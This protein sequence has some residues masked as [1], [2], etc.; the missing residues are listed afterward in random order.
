MKRIIICALMACAAVLS[1]AQTRNATYEAYIAKYKDIALEQERLHKIPAAITMAQGLLESGAG[2]GRLA[3]EG[4]NHF[5]IKCAGDWT[6]E[7]IRHDDETK[8]ECFRKYTTA[9]QS[10]EDHSQFLLRKRY[11]SLFQLDIKDYQGWA[12]GLKACGYATDPQYAAKLIKLIEDYDL[13]NLKPGDTTPVRVIG[14]PDEKAVRKAEENEDPDETVTKAMKGGKK[15]NPNSM[16]V[17]DLYIQRPIQRCNGVRYVVAQ[18]GDSFASLAAKY[19]MREKTLRR[20]NDVAY[21]Y[22][23]QPGDRVYLFTKKRHADRSVKAV[24]YVGEGESA[25]SISQKFGM[26][27][28][29]LYKINGITEG[30]GVRYNQELRLR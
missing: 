6:G 28:Q 23:L 4:N 15:V 1:Q 27:L 7:T 13:S 29:S 11:A 30:A 25:W 24:Y 18:S 19:G 26:R 10:Y 20:Y 22:E 16:G 5:G 3:R 17:V 21:W 9:A 2:Q 14:V 8:N 12:N